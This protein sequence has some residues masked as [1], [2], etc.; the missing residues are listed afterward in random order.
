MKGMA[1]IGGD[2]ISEA[3][4]ALNDAEAAFLNARMTLSKRRTAEADSFLDELDQHLDAASALFREGSAESAETRLYM[5]KR[6]IRIL[7]GHQR[8]AE[9]DDIDEAIAAA[10]ET[11][12]LAMA[13]IEEIL[14]SADFAETA[15]WQAK[16]AVEREMIH[17]EMNSVTRNRRE[18][19][20]ATDIWAW[21]GFLVV[22]CFA[23]WSVNFLV[24]NFRWW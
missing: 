10:R 6:L 16:S 13:Q 8:S 20:T 23:G 1:V 12:Q 2:R 19:L 14:L 4:Q 18:S 17:D 21:I 7:M 5:A 22:L 3:R 11:M 9:N 15:N 24:S